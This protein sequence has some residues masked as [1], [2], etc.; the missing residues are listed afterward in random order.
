MTYEYLH[1]VEQ[2]EITTPVRRPLAELLPLFPQL[3]FKRHDDVVSLDRKGR[4]PP[5][6]H[7]AIVEIETRC[8]GKEMFGFHE[9]E[10]DS[11]LLRYLFATLPYELT[12]TFVDITY[13]VSRKLS[14]PVKQHGVEI[15]DATLRERFSKTRADL[16]SE[17]GM[18]AGSEELAI[19]I[20]STYPR[21]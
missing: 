10:W 7:S 20:H 14:L 21:R 6:Q 2:V 19:L 17:T 4:I 9:G 13:A 5:W 18:D 15:D 12:N 11:I 3:G 1:E 16:T 8:N